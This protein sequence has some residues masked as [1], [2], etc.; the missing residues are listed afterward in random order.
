MYINLFLHISVLP[1]HDELVT[2]LSMLLGDFQLEVL[3]APIHEL[4]V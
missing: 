1:D 2:V 3:P 4:F